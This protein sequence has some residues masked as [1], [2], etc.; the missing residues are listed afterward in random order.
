M[1]AATAQGKDEALA[2]GVRI[3]REM[4]R[5]VADRVQGVQVSAPLGRVSVALEVLEVAL[6]GGR[7]EGRKDGKKRQAEIA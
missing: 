6:T 3:A 1:R 4:L 5:A 2:E 7:A